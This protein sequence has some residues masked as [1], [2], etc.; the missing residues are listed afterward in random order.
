MACGQ[1]SIFSRAK[2]VTGVT[3]SNTSGATQ[4]LRL[5]K[6]ESKATFV[7]PLRLCVAYVKS[8]TMKSIKSTTDKSID[9]E[10]WRREI[11]IP[12]LYEFTIDYKD[13]VG[14]AP[15]GCLVV[16]ASDD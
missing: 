2:D 5:D 6:P 4:M 3:L 12:A 16:T 9:V 11:L 15:D 13:Y 10:N 1:A 7:G 14:N 8:T